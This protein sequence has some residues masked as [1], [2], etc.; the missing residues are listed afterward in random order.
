MTQA[1]IQEILD[2]HQE[3]LENASKG[4]RADLSRAELKRAKLR[5]ARLMRARLDEADRKSV[6]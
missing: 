3:W 4:Q 2:R 1:E 5:G 6:V